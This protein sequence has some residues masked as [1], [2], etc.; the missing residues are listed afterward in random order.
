MKII[1]LLI[2]TT[3]CASPMVFKRGHLKKTK[4]KAYL[5]KKDKTK[6]FLVKSKRD[7]VYTDKNRVYVTTKEFN[8]FKTLSPIDKETYLNKLIY[9]GRLNSLYEMGTVEL[10]FNDITH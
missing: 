5:C 10:D 6:Y 1:L 3:S 7:E 9:K 8:H 2:L 4:Q